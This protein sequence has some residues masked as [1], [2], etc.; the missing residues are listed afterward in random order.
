MSPKQQKDSEARTVEE[1]LAHAKSEIGQLQQALEISN[2]ARLRAERDSESEAERA[3]S[4]TEEM[5][6]FVYAI[7]HDL[8]QPLR[9]I[10]SYAQLIERRR[11]DDTEIKELTAFVIGGANE[12]NVLLENILKFSRVGSCCQ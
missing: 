10:L 11:P 3:R 2:S 9:S 5:Q 12:M 8:R 1:E 6:H 4:A 7:S